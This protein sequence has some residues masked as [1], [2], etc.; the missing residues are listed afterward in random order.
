MLFEGEV[1]MGDGGRSY[2]SLR[3]RVEEVEGAWETQR[4][5]AGEAGAGWVENGVS[6]RLLIP[7]LMESK[8]KIGCRA[9]GCDGCA[10]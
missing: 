2:W 8:K 6:G 5:M 7:L 1:D 3:E 4:E 10:R 9:R